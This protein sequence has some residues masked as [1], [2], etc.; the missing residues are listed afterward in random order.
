VIAPDDLPVAALFAEVVGQDVA[1]STLR[2]AA[3]RPVHAY[4]FLGGS[5]S[6]VRPAARAFGAALLCPS[7]GCGHCETCR[8][9]LA[10]TH[11][12]LVM[13]ERTGAALGVD[14]ARRVAMLAQRRP[15]EADRQVLVVADMHL[16][17][18][19]APALLKTVEEPPPATVFVLLC[20]SVP[21][22]LVTIASR[23]AEVRFPSLSAAVIEQ[24]L[25]TRGLDPER[26]SVVADGA[27][28]DL[29]RARLLAEDEGF[30]GRHDLWRSVPNRLSGDGSVAAGLARDL[31]AAAEAAVAPLR[32]RHAE[33]MAALEAES[34]SL[35]EKTVPGRRDIVDRQ[36][37]EERRW[38]TDEIRAGLGVLARAYRDRLATALSSGEAEGDQIE[39]CAAATG[40]I[41]A[42]AASLER[43]PNESLLLESLLVRLGSSP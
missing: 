42:A 10:G 23:C 38:R 27:G 2:A 9:T 26:A 17:I 6:G 34:E 24:W 12:D 20:D 19:S 39:R 5:G 14:D 21:P 36:H 43:N 25:V 31:L 4:L 33:E 16:A 18:R 8:R 15:F 40:A 13:V 11:P 35:G 28:G 37:R 22:E 1:V 29:E 32:D 41:T 7:G 3:R 30:V